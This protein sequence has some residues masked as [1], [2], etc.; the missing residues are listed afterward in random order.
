[1]FANIVNMFDKTKINEF[2]SNNNEGFN[3]L[4]QK[5]GMV[6]M[7]TAILA[8]VTAEATHIKAVVPNANHTAPIEEKGTDPIRR[9]K[10]AETHHDNHPHTHTRHSHRTSPDGRLALDI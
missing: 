9:D 8:T 5:L 3:E 4:S 1:M 6:L 2:I 10:D 7:S